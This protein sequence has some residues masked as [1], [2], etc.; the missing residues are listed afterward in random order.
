MQN[1]TW[2]TNN[3][4]LELPAD[5]LRAIKATPIRISARREDQRC[6]VSSANREFETKSAYLLAINEDLSIQDF[7]GKWLWKLWT[8]PKIKIFLWKCYHH[9]LPVNAIFE[10]RVIEGLGDCKSCLDPNETIVHVLRDC[11]E[12]QCFWRQANCPFPLWQSFSSDYLDWIHANSNSKLLASDKDYPWCVFFLLGIWTLWLQRN[13]KIFGQQCTNSNIMQLVEMQT[14]EFLYCVAD[15]RKGKTETSRLVKWLKPHDGWWKLN[16]D[17][18]FLASSRLVSGGG[19]IWDLR[20]QCIGGF[21]KAC[22]ITSSLVVELW[23]LRE[24]LLRCIE[25]QA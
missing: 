7:A 4:S 25:M 13:R 14:K 19:I 5:V 22:A 12:A 23:A 2:A 17:G 6:W 3:V 10:H 21:A 15:L 1:G 20:G 8:L 16:T 18:F 24:G 11:P 9:S